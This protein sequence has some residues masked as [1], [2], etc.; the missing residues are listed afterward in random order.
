MQ[1]AKGERKKAKDKMKDKI[2]RQGKSD[3]P[4]QDNSD[5][6]RYYKQKTPQTQTQTQT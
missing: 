6:A 3:K 2:Q 5:T 1:N 4:G